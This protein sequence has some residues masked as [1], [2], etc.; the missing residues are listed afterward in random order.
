MQYVANDGSVRHL[1]IQRSFHLLD[2]ED[3]IQLCTFLNHHFPALRSV[4]CRDEL[5]IGQ[6]REPLTSLESQD[7]LAHRRGGDIPGPRSRQISTT[8]SIEAE[9]GLPGNSLGV[10]MV[11]KKIMFWLVSPIFFLPSSSRTT[12]SQAQ[13]CLSTIRKNVIWKSLSISYRF[14]KNRKFGEIVEIAGKFQVTTANFLE[15][16]KLFI[17]F[18]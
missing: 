16:S 1:D 4:P 15:G 5:S 8:K 12:I 13:A 18:S 3:K 2:H 6:L 17:F 9:L 14:P 11:R 10:V 7:D